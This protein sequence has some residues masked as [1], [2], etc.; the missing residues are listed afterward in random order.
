MADWWSAADTNAIPTQRHLH[1]S[2]VSL[3]EPQSQRYV[4]ERYNTGSLSDG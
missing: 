2:F 3:L 1:R 4:A